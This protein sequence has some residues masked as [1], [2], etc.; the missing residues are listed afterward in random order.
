MDVAKSAQVTRPVVFEKSEM[1][2]YFQPKLQDQARQQTKEKNKLQI[3]YQPSG[4][5]REAKD[6]MIPDAEIQ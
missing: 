4:V 6:Q 2:A 1:D 5:E 3:R